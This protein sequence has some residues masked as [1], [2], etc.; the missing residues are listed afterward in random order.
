[1]STNNEIDEGMG[2]QRKPLS[3]AFILLVAGV[4]VLTLSSTVHA[5]RTIDKIPSVEYREQGYTN[6]EAFVA[7]FTSCVQIRGRLEKSHACVDTACV[8]DHPDWKKKNCDRNS[9]ATYFLL[10]KP[11]LPV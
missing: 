9:E 2:M 5:Q 4:V 7:H 6:K 3:L 11:N 10:M 8:R 1:M